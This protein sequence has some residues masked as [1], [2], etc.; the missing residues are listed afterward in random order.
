[1][2]SKPVRR[3]PSTPKIDSIFDQRPNTRRARFA[4]AR[5]I[6]REAETVLKS[7][8]SPALLNWWTPTFEKPSLCIARDSLVVENIHDDG[9]EIEK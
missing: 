5:K 1:M 2:T 8:N 6:T 7:D 3:T 4:A 9:E